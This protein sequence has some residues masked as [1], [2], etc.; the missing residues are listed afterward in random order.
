MDAKL[1]F[2]TGA[3]ANMGAVLWL[4]ARG[5]RHR[6]RGD[7]P[8]H[9]RAMRA[10]AALVL[11]FLFSYLLKLAL[12]GREPLETWSRADVWV[13]RFHELCVATMLLAGGSAWVRSLALRRT[14]NATRDPA[15]APAP[16]A[17]ASW[18]RRAGWA[19][20]VAAGAGFAS[21]GLVLAGMYHRAGLI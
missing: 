11:L 4:A 10:A 7:V 13:L 2:W 14:R 20:V 5:V 12:L 1:L 17:L 18:H 6:R 21:A 8:S 19:A 9:R 15:D 3:F 16:P